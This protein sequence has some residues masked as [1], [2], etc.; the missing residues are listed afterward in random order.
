MRGPQGQSSLTVRTKEE[1]GPALGKAAAKGPART[2][3]PPDTPSALFQHTVLSKHKFLFSTPSSH[4][5]AGSDWG[6]GLC[7]YKKLPGNLH[8]PIEIPRD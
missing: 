1:E 7:I 3:L 2:C 4:S 8:F 5:A 6:L